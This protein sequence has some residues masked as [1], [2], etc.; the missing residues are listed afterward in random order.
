M[1]KLK[2]VMFEDGSFVIVP[3]HILHSSFP[4]ITTGT[5]DVVKAVSAGFVDISETRVCCF[6]R[7]ESLNLDSRPQDAELMKRYINKSC[8]EEAV[9]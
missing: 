7:S 3:N 5:D 6:G 8:F 9:V 2:Y 4:T 1:H